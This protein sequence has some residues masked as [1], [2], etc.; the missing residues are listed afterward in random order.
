MENLRHIFR[1]GIKELLSLFRDPVLLF[2]IAYSFTFSV[3]TPAKS[4]VMDVINASV[5]IVIN[6]GVGGV[7]S[8]AVKVSRTTRS[9]SATEGK[10]SSRTKTS[11]ANSEGSTAPGVVT[12][13]SID[14]SGSD[15]R[16]RIR[17]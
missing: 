7:R 5:A 17:R 9:K 3:Y 10:G 16:V 8:A 14:E 2:L 1:L 15:S 4:A 13:A 6:S 11:D 12:S